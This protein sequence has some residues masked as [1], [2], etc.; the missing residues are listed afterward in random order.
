LGLGLLDIGEDE[1]SSLSSV[2]EL[3]EAVP[4]SRPFTSPVASMSTN[5]LTSSASIEPDLSILASRYLSPPDPND[6]SAKYRNERRYRML[7]Q[8]EYHTI[9]TLPL[10]RP[11]HVEVGAVGFLSKPDGHFET[12]FNAFEPGATSGGKADE[13]PML[14]GYGK[15]SKGSQRQDKRNAAQRGL[16]HLHGLLSSARIS[17]TQSFQLR[18]Q[19]KVAYIYAE[20]TM[21]RYIANVEVPKKWFQSNIDHIMKIYGREQRLTREDIFLVIGALDAPNYASFVSHSHPDGQVNFNVF[22]SPQVGQ[23]WG[24]FTLTSAE[25]TM[26]SSTDTVQQEMVGAVTASNVSLVQVKN[27]SESWDSILLARLRFKPDIPEP[28]SL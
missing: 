23:P 4:L 24:E 10:W 6:I 20:S 25:Q 7:L 27:S 14:S 22:A 18:T 17:R 11:S 2:E 3:S 5:T 28:T 12:L 9:L 8:H 19:H 1:A 21:Y 13:L 16:D 26:E 15:I